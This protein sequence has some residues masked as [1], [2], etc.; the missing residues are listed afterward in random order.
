MARVLVAGRIHPSGMALLEAE[1]GIV[2]DPGAALPMDR[3]GDADA[4]LI[5]GFGRI[6]REVAR[7]ARAFDMEVPVHD[8]LVPDDGV[9]A[10]GCRLVADWRACL[11]AARNILGGLA[12]TLKPELIFNLEQLRKARHAP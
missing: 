4:L 7:R 2:S 9:E 5:L 3:L 11:P 10:L 12:G 8:P 1:P 6:G